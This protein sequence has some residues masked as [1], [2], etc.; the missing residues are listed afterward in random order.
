MNPN[1]LLKDISDP[2]V[3]IASRPAR[4]HRWIL[5]V[6]RCGVER[7]LLRERDVGCWVVRR[8]VMVNLPTPILLV[9]HFEVLEPE[10]R[11]MGE[12]QEVQAVV[13]R[14]GGRCAEFSRVARVLPIGG[15]PSIGRVVPFRP[16]ADWCTGT[17]RRIEV[18]K[19]RGRL[20]RTA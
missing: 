13:L 10:R 5:R 8:G 14:Q 2:V 18:C 9:A 7:E 4:P 6:D 20:L 16:V 3:V 1:G 17:D 15:L 11:G 12:T 19:E